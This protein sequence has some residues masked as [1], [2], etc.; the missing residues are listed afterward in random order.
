M[1]RCELFSGMADV[2][3]EIAFNKKPL[4]D[5]AVDIVCA[6]IAIPIAI[7][8]YLLTLPA[9]FAPKEKSN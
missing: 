9:I 3:K 8:A 6:L 1:A 7:P 5:K 2:V 4:G